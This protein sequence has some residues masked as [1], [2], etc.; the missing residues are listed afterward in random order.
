MKIIMYLIAFFFI[1]MS[2]DVFETTYSFCENVFEFLIHASIGIIFFLINFLF[3]KN[4]LILGISLIGIATFFFFF[5]GVYRD[6]K[7]NWFIFFGIIVPVIIA[8]IVHIL[9]KNRQK[10]T[11]YE[12]TS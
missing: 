1:F 7:Q 6:I 5:F 11:S 10:N 8:G 2:F 12:K 4:N 3:R 9:A